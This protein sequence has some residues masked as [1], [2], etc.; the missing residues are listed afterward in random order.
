[1][2][3]I[4]RAT[5]RL[6]FREGMT[7][8]RAAG[9]VPY[10]RRLGVSHL[11]A[12]PI[13]QAVSGSTHGYDVTDPTRLDDDLGG[14]AGFERLSAAL[15]DEGLGLILDIVPNHMAASLENPWYR[16]VIRHGGASR[17]ARHFDIDWSADKLL[18]TTLGAPYGDVLEKSEF[19][20]VRRADGPAFQV[21]DKAF[22][23]DPATW[24]LVFDDTFGMPSVPHAEARTEWFEAQDAAA[25][26]TRLAALSLDPEA[27]HAIHEAQP[28]RLTYWR[29]ARDTL[30]HRR[31]FEITDLIGLRVEDET[32]FF[33]AHALIFELIERG[34]VHGLR[35]DHV[36]GLADPSGYLRDLHERMPR[37]ASGET[38]PV[39]VEKI[40]GPHER[41]P[42]WP[43]EG[44][45]GYEVATWVAGALTDSAG[46]EPLTT[47]YDAFT[48]ETHDYPAMLAEAKREIVTRNLAAELRLLTLLAVEI[49]RGD[50]T[51]RDYGHDT[52][53]RAIV[54]LACAMPVY[55]LYLGDAAAD[56]RDAALLD[57]AVRGAVETIDVE[58]AGAVDFIAGLLRN[59]PETDDPLL[60]HARF[61][62]RFQQTTGA[63][64]AKALED[65]LFYRYHRLVALNEVGGEPDIFGLPP[66]A[67][68][69]AVAARAANQPHGIISTATHDTKRGEDARMRIAAI[70]ERPEEW[71]STVSRFD[72]ELTARLDDAPDAEMRWLFF[73]AL[74]GAWEGTRRHLADRLSAFLVKA[75]REAKGET[76][77]VRTD[78]DYEGRLEAMVAAAMDGD[79][80]ERF[81]DATAA[82]RALGEELSLA[83]LA[84]K[85]TLP[86]VPDIYQG[87]EGGDFSLVDPDN[88][89]PP[90]FE[91]LA[92]GGEGFAG[93]K[94]RLLASFLGCRER[95]P[96]LFE[97]GSYE[98]LEIDDALAFRR[99]HGGV[100]LL[101]I[102]RSADGPATFDLPSI[103]GEW[104]DWAGNAVSLANGLE[105]RAEERFKVLFRGI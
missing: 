88:R 80:L 22:P 98:P 8:E 37:L 105:M 10:L 19:S 72:G 38:V 39:W 4:P 62:R 96:D 92:K 97:H 3:R 74:H 73:Q 85:M 32:V 103:G 18:L 51:A 61:R 58:D 34:H 69:E 2:N 68:H 90:D 7:F 75:A 82:I 102:V 15:H 1:M 101:T 78:E 64:M 20:L 66:G 100:E 28:W 94:A 54:A 29:A 65:T 9:L 57:N 30:T 45:T 44:T 50:R 35:V 6:Q 41:L 76:S 104:T 43:V 93:R 71:A 42:D 60:P 17:Y 47:A 89:R 24:D 52:L 87:T 12:S 53:R 40:L 95:V 81:L 16:D 56:A 55:R 86:G 99:A 49:A 27:L 84:L 36:D 59:A 5:Y 91:A 48:G 25:I 23:L 63:L 67:F 46:E 13:F 21:Y 31:F 11:Y 33:D 79:W 83:Q 77:W 14:R 26:D 70:A